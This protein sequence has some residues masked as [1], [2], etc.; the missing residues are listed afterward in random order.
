V[1]KNGAARYVIGLV[2]ENEITWGRLLTV[3]VTT[4]DW[5]SSKVPSVALVARIV[6]EPGLTPVT[7]AAE[8]DTLETNEHAPAGSSVTIAYVT[9]PVPLPPDTERL[10]ESSRRIEADEAGGA[11]EVA[12]DNTSALWLTP[13]IVK[14]PGTKVIW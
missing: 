3:I 12:A 1:T 14:V 10:A 11:D 13:V 2:A 9:K 8:V 5:T 7:V 6:H 4:L